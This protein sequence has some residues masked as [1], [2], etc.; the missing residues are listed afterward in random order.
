[1]MEVLKWA[2]VISIIPLGRSHSQ[3][4]A[5]LYLIGRNDKSKMLVEGNGLLL[6]W[7]VME[8]WRDSDGAGAKL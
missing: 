2:M 5:L 7:L 3:G 6:S 4:L 1:M 8:V